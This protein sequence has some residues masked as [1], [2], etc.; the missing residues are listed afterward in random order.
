MIIRKEKTNH[1]TIIPN[2]LACDE[3][4]SFEARGVLCYLLSKPN[5]WK[6]N[7]KDIQRSG[8]IGRQKAY[9]ILSELIESG[10]VHRSKVE[11]AQKKH[12]YQYV[13]YDFSSAEKQHETVDPV[14]KIDTGASAENQHTY[15]DS[16]TTKNP[17]VA[18]A[19]K[20]SQ[21]SF[22]FEE[23]PYDPKKVLFQEILPEAIAYTRQGEAKLRPLFG[24]WLKTTKGD[25]ELL[26]EVIRAALDHQ[27]GEFVSFVT[28][29][30]K[31]RMGENS[32]HKQWMDLW[33]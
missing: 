21:Q 25:A 2:D 5:D 7:C 32:E 13:I 19:T 24:R 3:R 31:H 11:N 27:P 22:G 23:E 10:Y 9:S 14:L 20:G 18:K 8:D 16:I 6:V 26:A 4:L 28:G 17:L 15:K 29:S 1:F 30:L 12:N 33:K